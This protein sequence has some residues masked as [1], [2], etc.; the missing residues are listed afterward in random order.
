M[1]HWK[2]GLPAELAERATFGKQPAAEVV[3]MIA[4]SDMR[5]TLLAKRILEK[6]VKS[7]KEEWIPSTNPPLCYFAHSEVV[8]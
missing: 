7:Q 3:D 6:D 4:K 8:L 5:R 1:K 2:G